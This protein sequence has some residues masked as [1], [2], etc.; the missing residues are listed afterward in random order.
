MI[1][2]CNLWFVQYAIDISFIKTSKNL[3]LHRIFQLGWFAAPI[4]SRDGDY[5]DVM[6]ERV[7]SNSKREGRHYSRLPTFSKRWVKMI[8]GSAD[9]LGLN[10]YSS[11][12][13]E[14]LDEPVGPHPSYV[15]DR[16]LKELT[17]PEWKR[18]ASE[19]LYSVPQGLGDILRYSIIQ[20]KS[21]D[22]NGIPKHQ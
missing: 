9:F 22:Q 12:F 2:Q 19:W 1:A 4:F 13:V 14:E 7:A 10:Y 8:R 18:A 20:S 15:R 6:V 11:R 17:K 3:T 16:N 21:Q 5:P